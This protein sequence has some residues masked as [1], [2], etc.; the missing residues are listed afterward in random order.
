MF[1]YKQTSWLRNGTQCSE[2]KARRRRAAVINFSSPKA[3]LC[4]LSTKCSSTEFETALRTLDSS[5]LILK[6]LYF[7]IIL[8]TLPELTIMP[9]WVNLNE[10]FGCQFAAEQYDCSMQLCDFVVEQTSLSCSFY[11]SYC[12]QIIG[13]LSGSKIELHDPGGHQHS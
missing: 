9:K 5:H 3:D 13:P 11:L 8:N 2:I 7:R 4:Q 12:S 1:I 10:R 6:L